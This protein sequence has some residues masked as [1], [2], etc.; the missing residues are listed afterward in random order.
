M[1]ALAALP[2]I[3]LGGVNGFGLLTEDPT[4]KPNYSC[5]KP[6]A[7]NGVQGYFEGGHRG[8][9]CIIIIFP[10]MSFE[11]SFQFSLDCR[12]RWLSPVLEIIDGCSFKLSNFD[13]DFHGVSVKPIHEAPDA[14]LW[15]HN[16]SQ[17]NNVLADDQHGYAASE[18]LT[19]NFNGETVYGT[20]PASKT[21][22]QLTTVSIY[23]IEYDVNFAYINIRENPGGEN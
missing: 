23:C 6:S 3:A 15:V 18:D 14:K 7:Y 17:K 5:D 12:Y 1:R 16:A 11:F 8:L 9:F 22:D 19:R 4:Q 2:L 10:A 20:I 21:W 13:F